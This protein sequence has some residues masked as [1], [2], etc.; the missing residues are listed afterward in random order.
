MSGASQKAQ[1]CCEYCIGLTFPRLRMSLE[2]KFVITIQ[3][4]REKT[5]SGCAG[6]R[7]IHDGLV[8]FFGSEALRP[9]S[10]TRIHVFK[11]GKMETP[12]GVILESQAL[13]PEMGHAL[14]FYTHAGECQDKAHMFRDGKGSWA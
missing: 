2:D 5:S 1:D 14:Q 3:K 7:V 10:S 12:M 6:C 9:L 4:L 11:S 8:A 13:T